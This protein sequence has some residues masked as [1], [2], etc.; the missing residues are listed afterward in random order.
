M[1]TRQILNRQLEGQALQIII[2]R[3]IAGVVAERQ[4]EGV[5][6]RLE[7]GEIADRA[8]KCPAADVP[9]EA[10]HWKLTFGRVA[11]GG[12]IMRDIIHE[13]RSRCTARRSTQDARRYRILGSVSTPFC[14]YTAG[15]RQVLIRTI[16]DRSASDGL[17]TAVQIIGAGDAR[18]SKRQNRPDQ[19]HNWRSSRY[20]RHAGSPDWWSPDR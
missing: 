2:G 4:V 6:G 19:D 16:D 10:V 5:K 20:P 18:C 14:G 11:P 1:L 8:G 15:A 9:P 17:R 3:H 12:E 13:I 7:I